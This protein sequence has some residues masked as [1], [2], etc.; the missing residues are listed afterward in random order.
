MQDEYLLIRARSLRNHSTP[1]E[2]KL[3]NQL[4]GAKLGGHKF[5]RQHVIDHAIV[6]FFCPGRGLIVEVDGDTHDAVKDAARDKR[7]A[8]LGYETIR[9]ANA[10][11]GKNLAGVLKALHSRLDELPSRWTTALPHPGPASPIH[12]HQVKPLLAVSGRPGD[13]RPD[14]PEGEGK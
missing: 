6:D 14:D 13:D 1:F 12:H 10:D 3:W 9:F 8:A 4:K 2:I 11:V 5:R 7:H